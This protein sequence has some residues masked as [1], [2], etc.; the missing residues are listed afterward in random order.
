MKKVMFYCHVFYPQNSGY[1]HAFQNLINSILDFNHDIS[2][3][4]VTP[5]EL[6]DN[7]E[8]ERDRLNIVRLKPKVDIRKIRYFLNE[9]FYA[10]EV[11]RLFQDGKYEFL[12]IETFDQSIFINFLD[13]D[14]FLK[15]IV[16]IHST[17]ETEYTIFDKNIEYRIRKI[18]I[19]EFVSK[20]VINI[21]STNDFHIDFAKKYYF[22][23]N[24]IEI[25]NKN[26]FTI[27]N[28]V[29]L[30]ES[31]INLEI[32]DRLKLF[33]LGRMD[34]LGFNQKGFLDFI[35]ALKLLDQE[36][37]DRF[38]ITVVGEGDRKSQILKLS[39]GFDNLLFIDSLPHDELISCMKESD[40]VVLPSRYEGLSMFA[41]EGLSTG[42][43]VIFSKTGGLIDLVDNNGLFFEPQNIDSLAKALHDMS[44]KTNKEILEMKKRSI[45]LVREKFSSEVVAK[46]FNKILNLLVN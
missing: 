27:P 7:K 18:L 36:V 13:S 39:Q 44:Q 23:N 45:E 4:V 38:E 25:G 12:F 28:T 37:L 8:I 14:I 3:T 1:S 29:K 11:S 17:N 10:K 24:V 35:F 34:R 46:K 40:I 32:G 42:N 33:I 20:K 2:I 31:N 6:G 22:N 19:R 15:T 16:R 9:Y 26:F 41:L 43:A 5:Y 21:A 30:D